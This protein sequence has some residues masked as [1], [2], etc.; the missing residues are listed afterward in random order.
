MERTGAESDA[1]AAAGA[2]ERRPPVVGG[3]DVDT[4][5]RRLVKILAKNIYI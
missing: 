3:P 1:V 5:W 4:G 2:V